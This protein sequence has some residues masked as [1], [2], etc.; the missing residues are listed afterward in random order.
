M[1]KKKDLK[2]RTN[3]E[4]DSMKNSETKQRLFS[5]IPAVMDS[6]DEDGRTISI[7]SDQYTDLYRKAAAWSNFIAKDTESILVCNNMSM[8][9]NKRMLK[10]NTEL[11]RK[12][13]KKLDVDKLAKKDTKRFLDMIENSLSL[14]ISNGS[15]DMIC[16]SFNGLVN[17]SYILALRNIK[18]VLINLGE[19]IVLTDEIDMIISDEFYN[20]AKYIDKLIDTICGEGVTAI[21]RSP[22]PNKPDFNRYIFEYDNTPNDIRKGAL[23]MKHIL[24]SNV[25]ASVASNEFY[26]VIRQIFSAAFGNMEVSPNGGKNDIP[27]YLC[28]LAE[29]DGIGLFHMLHEHIIT[30]LEYAYT[31]IK[32]YRENDVIKSSCFEG[33][34]ER[35]DD[36]Y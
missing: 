19:N 8:E 10:D 18:Q 31:I 7:V 32:L 13:L 33:Y 3:P 22:F 16:Q 5:L 9:I 11:L 4:Y 27:Y 21:N 1:A 2:V 12:D 25:T 6:F 35:D 23:T 20:A 17:E 14:A 29:I 26:W 15:L 30:I 28:L 24:L 36:E 34:E